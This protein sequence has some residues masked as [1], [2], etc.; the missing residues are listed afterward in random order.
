MGGNFATEIPEKNRDSVEDRTWKPPRGEPGR[1][2]GRISLRISECQIARA[3]L[4]LAVLLYTYLLYRFQSLRKHCFDNSFDNVLKRCGY[5][6]LEQ[7]LPQPSWYRRCFGCHGIPWLPLLHCGRK[8][9]P[10]HSSPS[11]YFRVGRSY[12]RLRWS[13]DLWNC[14]LSPLEEDA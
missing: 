3:I 5:N 13:Y 10:H 1:G 6:A 11:W 7:I 4:W 2:C 8:Y 9:G 12:A 14:H